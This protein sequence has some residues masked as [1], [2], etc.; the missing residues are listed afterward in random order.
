MNRILKGRDLRQYITSIFQAD[1]RNF[2]TAKEFYN[3][4]LYFFAPVIN[5]FY[6]SRHLNGKDI[7]PVSVRILIKAAGD[8]ENI[9]PKSW[10]TTGIRKALLDIAAKMSNTPIPDPYDSE[11]DMQRAARIKRNTTWSRGLHH[12]LRWAIAESKPGPPIADTMAI[13]G[14]NESLARL[15]NAAFLAREGDPAKDR[16]QSEMK[17][18]K[19]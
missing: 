8:F 18:V 13:L 1:P 2:T 4:S 11:T 14:R 16:S 3:R 7:H 5:E 10:T 15:K 12:Y 6:S 19:N 17:A 9:P